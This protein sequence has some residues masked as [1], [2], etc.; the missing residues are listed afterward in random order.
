MQTTP[1]TF[2]LM[3]VSDDK[4]TANR[5]IQVIEDAGRFTVSVTERVY[6]DDPGGQRVTIVFRSDYESLAAANTEAEK[7]TQ[8]SFAEGFFLN[9]MSPIG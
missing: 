9:I 4:I 3:K 7:Q 2:Y 1:L 5:T 6:V 8:L